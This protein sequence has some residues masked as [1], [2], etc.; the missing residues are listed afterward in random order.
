M[1]HLTLSTESVSERERLEY[2]QEAASR[3]FLGLRTERKAQG[4]FFGR[5]DFYQAGPLPVSLL[6]SSSQRVYRGQSEIAR[7]SREVYYICM[8]QAGWC[9][10]RNSR[11]EFLTR[12]G[13]LELIDSTEPGEL[14]FEKDYRRIVL[15]VPQ[16][17]L[18]PRLTGESQSARAL[19]VRPNRGVRALA[20]S[21]LRSF[22]QNQL[23]NSPGQQVT[24]MMLVE[25]LA[26]AFSA[27]TEEP[28]ADTPSLREAWRQRVYS[29]V[30][31]NLADPELDPERIAGY[32][33][34][35][36]RYLHALFAES[37]VTLMRWVLSQRLERCREDMA[38][39]A[40]RAR[41]ILEIVFSW[42]FQD[43]T[44][45]GRAFKK[46]YGVTPREWRAEALRGHSPK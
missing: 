9:R 15:V 31:H 27:R 16:S 13:D 44:H 12:P 4:P 38:N 5:L 7:S 10:L 21:F 32:F 37:G 41:S 8:Q 42:G 25:L 35:S 36:P 46:A 19:V 22:V 40:L 39:P 30:E 34:I 6:H 24:S 17:E 18:R 1:Q 26:L 45:F 14:V 3:M 43:Q 23:H 28:P 20:S 33:G 2:W 11:Q 29:Y